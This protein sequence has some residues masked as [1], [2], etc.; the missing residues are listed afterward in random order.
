MTNKHGKPAGRTIATSRPGRRDWLAGLAAAS[1]A[2]VANGFAPAARASEADPASYPKR[3]VTLV[4]PYP[5]GGP[6]DVVARVVAPRLAERLG[7]ALV[8]DNRPGASGT[9]GAALVARAAPDGQTLLANASIHVINPW[10]LPRSPYEAIDDFVGITQLVDVPLVLVVT[11]ELPVASVAELL[12]WLKQ[13]DARASF[14]S[15][16]NASA[17]HLSG[18]LFRIRSGAALTHVPYKGSQPALTD[19]V[20]GQIQLMFDSMPSAM[21]FIEAGRV[22]ALAVTTERRSRVLPDLPT[23]MEAGVADFRTSTWYGLWAP[24]GTPGGIVERIQA[25]AARVIALPE[26]IEQYRRLGAEP[27]ASTPA[28]FADFLAAESRKWAEI[29]RVSGARAD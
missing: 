9:L 17:Q 16:G 28:A 27:V 14:G 19:L 10:V 15:A 21:P 20:G 1:A 8:V 23:M 3:P 26:V 6:T 7:Q 29:V 11:R 24:K 13:K 4:V 12:A 5:P 22:R 2:A 18:E 25:E